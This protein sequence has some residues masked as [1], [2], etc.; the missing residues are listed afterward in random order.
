M[1]EE[2]ASAYDHL[3]A[4]GGD[5]L[6]SLPLLCALHKKNGP[7]G[8]IH[9]D[10]H[11]DTWD[12]NFGAPVTH[13]SNF[14]IAIAEGLIDPTRMIQIDICCSVQP[15]VWQWTLDQG[16]TITTADEVHMSTPAG[17]A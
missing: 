11:V 3:I 16:V 9:F 17:I 1:I 5:H 4:L 15:D 14:R 2:Q 8:M 6:I 10:A 12:N 7:V 13:G